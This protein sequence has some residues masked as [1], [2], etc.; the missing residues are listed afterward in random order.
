MKQTI[1]LPGFVS[2]IDIEPDEFMLPLHEVVVNAIQS[3]E[4]VED[5]KNCTISIS[6]IRGEQMTI[7]EESFEVPYKPI[8]GFEVTDNGIGFI[9]KR[10]KAFDEVY[11]DINKNKG[12][13]GVGRYSVLACFGSMDIDSTFLENDKWL[14]RRFNFSTSKGVNPAGVDCLSGA[15]EERRCTKVSLNNYL[16]PFSEYIV[17][18]RVELR[19][20]AES[21][22]NHCLLYFTSGEIP[23]IRIYD[24]DAPGDAFIVNDLFNEI[25]KFDK[26][27]QA[28]KITGVEDDFCLNYIRSYTNRTH[29]VHLCANKREVGNKTTLSSY[30]PSFVNPLQEGDSKYFL[31][32]Y[33]TGKYLDEKVNVQ[34][35]KF[36]IPQKTEDKKVFDSICMAELFDNISGSI[37]TNIRRLLKLLKKREMSVYELISWMRRNPDLCIVIC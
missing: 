13:K 18:K 29:S 3:I 1:N 25:I 5:P 26:E 9:Q 11:T 35:T 36:L 31:S 27:V 16:K 32:I 37:K 2:S 10:F 7:K 19:D 6:V 17:K 34:R 23:V 21:I 8:K 14:N 30:I 33:V 28:V 22:I 15:T 12:C 4:D 24:D 20:I